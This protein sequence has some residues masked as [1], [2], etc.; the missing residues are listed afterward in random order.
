MT[1]YIEAMLES[2]RL[3]KVAED[4]AMKGDYDAAYKAIKL[5]DAQHHKM[6]NWFWSSRNPKK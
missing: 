3:L 4:A 1:D 2:K 5:M 6:L